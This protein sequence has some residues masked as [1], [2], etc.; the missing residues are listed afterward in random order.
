MKLSEINH[1]YQNLQYRKGVVGWIFKNL[2]SSPLNIL[3]TFFSIYLLYLIIPATINW[4]ILD[5][6]WQGKSNKDCDFSGGACWFFIDAR[7]N[8]IIY[9][10]YPQ[11]YLWRPNLVF[12][13]LAISILAVTTNILSAKLKIRFGVTA[14]I[15]LPFIIFII[16]KGSIFGI[17]ILHP[18][19]DTGKW[20]GLILTLILSLGGIM[21]C[22]P[23]GIMLALGRRCD[24]MP[25]VKYFCIAFIE[26][27]RGVPLITILFMAAIMLPLLLPE[28]TQFDKLGRALIGIVLFEAAYIAEVIRGGLQAIPRGQYEAADSLNLTYWKKTGLIIMPQTLKLVIPGIVNNFIA[29][30]KDTSLVS[31]I[32][33]WDLLNSAIGSTRDPKWI[34]FIIEAYVFAG[35]IYWIMC[36][37]TSKYSQHLEK[38]LNTTN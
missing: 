13:I 9:G 24:S 27:W 26:F 1:K 35:I 19:V 3:L 10:F 17:E 14:L 16:L 21:L 20:G 22:F 12:A 29:L 8:T 6:V 18:I 11:E 30:L 34:G 38:K 15:T 37:G 32:G 31:I 28:G 5:A 7:F 36:F 4:A 25:I 33:M 2:L 23:L